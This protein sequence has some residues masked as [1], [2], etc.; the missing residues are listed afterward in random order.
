M[1]P[2]YSSISSRAVIPAGASL[3]PGSLTR[4]ETEKLRRPLRPLRPCVPRR[5]SQPPSEQAMRPGPAIEAVLE[6]PG[7]ALVA[8]D[9]HQP[10]RRLLAHEAPFAAAGKPGAAEAAQAGILQDLDQLVGGPPSGAQL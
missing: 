10:R 3:T 4:P 2:Q 5:G 7:P 1:P 6:G 8:I 9:R